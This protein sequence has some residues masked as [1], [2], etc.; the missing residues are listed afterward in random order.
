MD[1]FII[2]IITSVLLYS[3]EWRAQS[4]IVEVRQERAFIIKQL[5]AWR[6]SDSALV[7]LPPRGRSP[8]G[9]GG[10]VQPSTATTTGLTVY[11]S[12]PQPEKLSTSLPAITPHSDLRHVM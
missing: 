1:K 9:G 6:L 3:A 10:R 4:T 7:L 2:T 11:W 12:K 8:Q 5:P